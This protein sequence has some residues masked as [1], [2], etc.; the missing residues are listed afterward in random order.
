MSFPV[1]ELRS[2]GVSVLDCEHKTP[3]AQSSGHPYIAIPDVQAGR[4]TTSTARRISTADL[5]DWNRRTTPTAGDILVTRR[6]RVGDTAP[7]PVGEQVAIGQNLVL[8]RST[9]LQ[10]DQTYL[11]WAARSP[12]W[13][14]EVE[15][16]L[17]VGAI[18]NS[19]NVKDIGRIKLPVPPLEHQ[20]AIAQVLGALDDKIAANTKLV[21]AVDALV[22]ARFDGLRAEA[23]ML[24]GELFELRREP[25]DPVR[26]GAHTAYV[27]LEH[28]PRKS[29]WLD[30]AGT[31]A[32][33]TSGKSYFEPGDVL[34]GKLRPYFHKVV[35][36]AIGGI[37]STDILVLRSKKDSFSGFG[38]A[39]VSSEAVVN[40]VTAASEGTRMPR[41]SWND[42]AAVEVPWPGEAVAREFSVAV[43]ALEQTVQSLLRENRTLAA[44][45]DALL[46]QLMSGKLRVRDAERILEDAGV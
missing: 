31:S 8:L 43:R 6:G 15:R 42:L 24:I 27:G 25:A 1:V 17:N 22:R 28:V 3:K 41:T 7:I 16:L 20:R 29:M 10:V 38:L 9:G 35:T 40:A 44:T 34:F 39:A 33:V 11:R 46:P 30:D 26:M 23:T 37:C 14:S 19:L 18:F 36:V 13:W 5:I 45:R 21:K 4:V 32:T 2:A 12:Q